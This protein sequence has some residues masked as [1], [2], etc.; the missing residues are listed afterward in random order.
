MT[1][2]H[3][4]AVKKRRTLIQRR[5]FLAIAFLLSCALAQCP[6]AF[7]QRGAH[8][9][10]GG[11]RPAGG[12]HAPMPRAAGPRV[13]PPLSAG[14]RVVVRPRALAA[15]GIR[16]FGGGPVGIHNLRFQ[17]G[18]IRGFRH[19]RFFAG[20]IIGI[21][22]DLRLNAFWWP[23][24][25][26]N[27]SWQFGCSGL[28]SYATDYRSGFENYVLMQGYENPAYI[29]GSGSEGRDLVWLYLKDG[30][31]YGVSDYWFVD[32]QVHFLAVGDGGIPSAEQVIDVDEFDL[33][34]TNDVNKTRGFRFVRRDAPW[35][36]YLKDR[37]NGT[38]PL[39]VPEKPEEK[40]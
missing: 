22:P 20:R 15:P 7:A 27:W 9:G 29:D 34:K 26:P 5:P 24:C 3:T 36:K 21:S 2:F 16:G 14:G 25:G 32:D 4:D 18:P 37:P 19:P 28:P 23:G 13:S 35:Q 40:D 10:G 30:T 11:A 39:V 12:T 1:R 6:P 31:I 8:A 33:Q 17:P 38:P